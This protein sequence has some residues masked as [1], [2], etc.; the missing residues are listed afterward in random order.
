MEFLA[1]W[2]EERDTEWTVSFHKFLNL[3]QENDTIQCVLIERT[4]VAD[5]LPSNVEMIND[6]FRSV[7]CMRN[8]QEIEVWGFQVDLSAFCHALQLASKIRRVSMGLV[9]LVNTNHCHISEATAEGFSKHPSLKTFGL[10]DF[11]VPREHDRLDSLFQALSTCPELQTV[12]LNGNQGAEIQS[13]WTSLHML[14]RTPILQRL[15][16]S[17]LRLQDNIA[18]TLAE[19]L[20]SNSH[21]EMLDLSTNTAV[22]SGTVEAILRAGRSHLRELDVR[23]CALSPIPIEALRQMERLEKLN[24]S[25]CTAV[26]ASIQGLADMLRENQPASLTRLEAARCLIQDDGCIALA[27]ALETNTTLR[28]LSLATNPMTDRS[29]LAFARALRVNRTLKYINLQVEPIGTEG[30]DALLEALKSNTVLEGLSTYLGAAEPGSWH[31]QTHVRMRLYLRLNHAN[32]GKLLRGE[33]SNLD[34]YLALCELQDSLN[35]IHHLV[36]SFPEIVT[37]MR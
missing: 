32:R 34:W 35:A 13:P 20:S 9:S 3:L 33:G 17:R 16:L 36:R 21:L 18:R 7:A 15:V 23:G 1:P 12:E 8:L 22:S 19:S 30:S 28:E 29:Y 6:I 24:I 4:F 37:K 31:V 26:G 2:S 14:P 11:R 27:E 5:L 10:S 25:R